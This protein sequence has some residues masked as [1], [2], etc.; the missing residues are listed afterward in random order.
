[1][2]KPIAILIGFILSFIYKL[3]NNY[4]ISIIILTLLTRIVM[5]PMYSKQI[6]YSAKMSAVQDEV[7]EIQTKYAANQAKMNEKMQEIYARE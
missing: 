4:G 2:L 6:E 3:V 5:L 7:K 1:M